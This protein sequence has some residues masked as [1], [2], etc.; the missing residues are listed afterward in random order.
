MSKTVGSM[1]RLTETPTAHVMAPMM[2]QS[3]VLHLAVLTVQMRGSS[4]VRLTETPTAHVMAPMMAR[5]LVLH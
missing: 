4:M 5:S 1:V 3:S 2:A